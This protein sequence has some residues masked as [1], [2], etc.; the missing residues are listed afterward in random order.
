M[1]NCTFWKQIFAYPDSI[2]VLPEYE[3]DPR[4]A[5]NLLDGVNFTC[6]DLHVWLAPF[7]PGKEH[8][9]IIEMDH[10]EC[11]SMARIWN[12]NKSRAHRFSKYLR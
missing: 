8:N 2:N 10:L 3:N 12:Y 5:K 11:I 9:I 7:T 6:D 4:I 1:I